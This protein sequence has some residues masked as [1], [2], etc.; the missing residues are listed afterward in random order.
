MCCN[1]IISVYPELKNVEK[2][3][4]DTVKLGKTRGAFSLT[5]VGIEKVKEAAA[6]G[7]STCS[8]EED[9]F[10]PWILIQLKQLTW[11]YGPQAENWTKGD[12]HILP[13]LP[14]ATPLP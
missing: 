12:E 14:M 6:H 4:T 3:V 10:I 2:A 5:P 7:T 13:E 8:V 1:H 9:Y 11:I